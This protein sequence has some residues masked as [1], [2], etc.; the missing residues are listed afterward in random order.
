MHGY[1]VSALKKQRHLHGGDVL[2]EVFDVP[3][4]VAGA[5]GALEGQQRERHGAAAV[6]L[7]AVD[8]R[9]R[10]GAGERTVLQ[11]PQVVVKEDAE[12]KENPPVAPYPGRATDAECAEER[13]ESIHAVTTQVPRFLRNFAAQQRGKKKKKKDSNPLG[14]SPLRAYVG[15]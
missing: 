14:Q 11:G 8:L 5:A 10:A 6:G 7:I 15:V 12:H 3:R 9:G 13:T 4:A 1:D 2:E